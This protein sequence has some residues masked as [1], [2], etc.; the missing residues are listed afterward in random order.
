MPTVHQELTTQN[1]AYLRQQ[2]PHVHWIPVLQGKTVQD[3][4]E[5]KAS[6]ASVGIDLRHEP[7]VGLGSVCRRQA[8]GQIAAIV[9]IPQ[10]CRVEYKVA[11]LSSFVLKRAPARRIATISACAVGSKLRSTSL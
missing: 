4:L 10:G 7:L 1:V 3:Y 2:F 11:P 6:Y 8:T 5:H 9:H